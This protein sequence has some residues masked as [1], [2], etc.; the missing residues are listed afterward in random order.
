MGG[1][2]RGRGRGIAKEASQQIFTQPWPDVPRMWQTKPLARTTKQ[3]RW[4]ETS[5]DTTSCWGR[6]WGATSKGLGS[7]QHPAPLPQTPNHRLPSS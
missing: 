7:S 6:D 4:S 2:G 3:A 5:P 1:G